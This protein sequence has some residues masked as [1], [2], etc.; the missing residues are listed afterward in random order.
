MQ[1][2]LVNQPLGEKT[3]KSIYLSIYSSI[4]GQQEGNISGA[5]QFY[6]TTS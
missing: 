5:C 6:I 1:D 3:F 4:N 2:S